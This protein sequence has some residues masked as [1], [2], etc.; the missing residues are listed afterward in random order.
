MLKSNCYSYS[1]R[2]VPCHTTSPHGLIPP[3]IKRVKTLV[4]CVVVTIISV[5]IYDI[6]VNT[7]IQRGAI[8]ASS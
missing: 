8:A 6:K 4:S 3:P 1:G 2:G 7:V 5:K